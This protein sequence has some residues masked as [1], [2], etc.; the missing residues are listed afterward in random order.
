MNI[1]SIR[2]SVSRALGSRANASPFMASALGALLL[3][4]SGCAEEEAFSPENPV[5]GPSEMLPNTPPLND[6]NF[7]GGDDVIPEPLTAAADPTA[8]DPTASDPTAGETEPASTEPTVTSC[9]EACRSHCG[10][11][12]LSNPVNQ[13]LCS[14]LWGLG[15][16]G[17]AIV[18]EEACR[19]L[20]MDTSGRY[21]TRSEIDE[22]CLGRPWG[23]VVAERIESDGFIRL[24]RRAWSDRL[25]YDTESVSVERIYDMDAIVTRLYEGRIAYD[26]FAAVASA[27]P[28]LT[29][30][31]ATPGDRAEA[32]FWTFLGRP[33]FGDERSDLGRL[34]NLWQNH[35]YDHPQLGMRLPDAFV[36]YRCVDEDGDI[37]PL[38]AGECT[39]INFGYEQLILKP[40]TRAQELENTNEPVMW[41]GFLSASEWE[42]LQAPGRLIS[43]EW[44]FWEHAV[45]LVL[46]QYL[47]YDLATM[48]PEVGEEL[49]RY[50]LAHDGDI[51]AAH[52]AVLSSYPYLQTSTGGD[53]AEFRFTYGPLKQAEAEGWIDSVRY[54]AGL[55]TERCDM[56]LN[57]PREFIETESPAAFALIVDSDWILNEERDDIQRNYRDLAQT[58]GGCPDN[59]QGGRFK[60]VSVLT[61]ANQLSYS[62]RICDPTGE[63]TNLQAPIARLLPADVDPNSAL[64]PELGERIFSHLTEQFYSR[65]ATTEERSQAQVHAEACSGCS[66]EQFARPTCYALLSSA[67]MLF[68]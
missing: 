12:N 7:P 32:L 39:S 43:Q 59:S 60:I 37:D 24:N 67:E 15:R 47:D 26:Q 19:R 61:T 22:Q 5:R 8:A 31:H 34:Y 63:G 23:D 9:D 29:R 21:P 10:A 50:V 3:S 68:Y 30:K 45:N 13:G 36:R 28:V 27:H 38:S 17:T 65:R 2:Q 42:K 62:G 44:A 56:R 51:R 35:Y 4:S 6:S 49:V 57:R 46:S 14:A 66:A 20:F 54:A 11:A 41:S 40:D 25:G 16:S 33:P 1:K 48:V 18:P 58:L 64:T 53:E 55:D 52:Y